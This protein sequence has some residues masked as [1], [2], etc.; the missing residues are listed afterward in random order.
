MAEK[1]EA[2]IIALDTHGD[3]KGEV[4]NADDMRL[5]QMG[6]SYLFIHANMD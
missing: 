4:H 2:N 5:Q 3:V 1:Y 6:S